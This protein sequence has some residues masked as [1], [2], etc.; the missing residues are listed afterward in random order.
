MGEGDNGLTYFYQAEIMYDAAAPTW[1]Y[2]CYTL[3]DKV[4]TH[5]ATGL[6]CYTYFRDASVYAP[7]GVN[8]GGAGNYNIDKAVSVFLNGNV[9]SG[10][11]NTLN[12]DG[13]KVDSVGHV[14]Y[15]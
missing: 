2:S 11:N 10:L 13:L 1:D 7:T 5:T 15:R 3:G 14:Q 9:N 12:Y 6:G 4:N 8:T